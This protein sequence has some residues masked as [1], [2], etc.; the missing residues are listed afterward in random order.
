MSDKSHSSN[1]NRIIR[2]Y[3]EKQAWQHRSRVFVVPFKIVF[4]ALFLILGVYFIISAFYAFNSPMTTVLALST[5][6]NDEY[7][8]AGYFVRGEQLIET[9]YDGILQYTIPDGS[10]VARFAPYAAVY[11]DESA[12]EINSKTAEIDS[13]I[14]SL[15][16][17][18]KASSDT[19][20]TE[21][22]AKSISEQLLNVTEISD[23]GTYTLFSQPADSLKTLIVN[24]EFAFADS[25]SIQK[26]ID[27]LKAQRTALRESL[28]EREKVLYTP[29]SGYFISYTD[30]YEDV[31][32]VPKLDDLTMEDF[33]ALDNHTPSKNEG[34]LGKI[35]TGF[36]WYF[37]C[38]LRNEEV[39][40]LSEGK[41]VNM[42]FDATGDL[43]INAKVHHIESKTADETV[44][45]F[46][47]DKHLD[48]LILL[49]KQAATII[50]ETYDGLKVP[51]TAL[52]VDDEGNIGVYVITGLYAEFKKI[53]PLYETRDYYIVET[54]P[55]TTK[56]LLANDT[57]IIN[58]KNL[59]HKKV[60]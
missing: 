20:S 28:G 4:G 2:T 53:K 32:T 35:V 6:V 39:S 58:G 8:V 40:N 29:Y 3:K 47:G 48:Q 60:L 57:I 54:D 27:A 14:K 7:S 55:T 37:V 34:V 36:D 43:L 45:V 18:L 59:S 23:E 17:A 9:D 49:R 44:V 10:K 11:A 42:Q 19:T 1:V 26:D 15:E 5:S 52:R 24:R 41:S 12:L 46:T 30:G 16:S 56:S 13:R 50:C 25:E 31:L 33:N 51:K 22:L 21:K 38:T